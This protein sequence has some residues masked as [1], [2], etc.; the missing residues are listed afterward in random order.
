MF[1]MIRSRLLKRSCVLTISHGAH[2]P[3]AG[4]G[5]FDHLVKEPELSTGEL[6]F[7][8]HLLSIRWG[9]ILRPFKYSLLYKKIFLSFSIHQ[10]FLLEPGFSMKATK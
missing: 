8:F 4:D 9:D 5:N 2:L 7:A 10:D 6:V 1:F 3:L